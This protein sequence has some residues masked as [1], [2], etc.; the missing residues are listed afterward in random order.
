VK[1]ALWDRLTKRRLLVNLC[2]NSIGIIFCRLLDFYGENFS[3]F[4]AIRAPIRDKTVEVL[5]PLKLLVFSFDMSSN[6]PAILVLTMHPDFAWIRNVSKLRLTEKHLD[7]SRRMK[8]H[9]LQQFLHVAGH[10]RCG[11]FSRHNWNWCGL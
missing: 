7:C 3:V 10:Q 4:R 6:T 5:F 9:V 8:W 2:A 1:E 11:G